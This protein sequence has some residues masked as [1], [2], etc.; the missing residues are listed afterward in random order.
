[1]TIKGYTTAEIGE[2]KRVYC[3]FCGKEISDMED[4]YPRLVSRAGVMED[5]IIGCTGCL[6][7]WGS[8]SWLESHE[9]R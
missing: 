1:M 8:E 3:P 5:I 4:G 2:D 6:D 7:M 9:R